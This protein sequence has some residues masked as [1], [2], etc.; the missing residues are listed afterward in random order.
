MHGPS[1]DDQLLVGQDCQDEEAPSVG[2][3]QV[4]G[5]AVPAGDGVED[6]RGEQCNQG[7]Q[8]DGE[9]QDQLERGSAVEGGAADHGDDGD[10]EE[11][12]L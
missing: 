12:G 10:G 8:G 7:E 3:G 1:G 9:D 6:E 4:Q 2:Q 11:A 5:G